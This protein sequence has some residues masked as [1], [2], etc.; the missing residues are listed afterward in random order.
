MTVLQD[1][2][3]LSSLEAPDEVASHLTT[4]H[5]AVTHTLC[6]GTVYTRADQRS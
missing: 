5:R 6:G 3:H 1:T 2:G 4:F